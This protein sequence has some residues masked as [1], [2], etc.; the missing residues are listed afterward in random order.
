VT[1]ISFNENWNIHKHPF[2]DLTLM[3]GRQE[4]HPACKKSRA[5]NSKNSFSWDLRGTRPNRKWFSE[6]GPYIHK[7]LSWCWQT[8]A[9]GL[10]VSQGHQT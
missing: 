8:R 1:I 10:E 3:I 6:L 9:T 7:K 2:S 4:G 5:S